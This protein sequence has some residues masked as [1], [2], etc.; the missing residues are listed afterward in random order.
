MSKKTISARF[1]E[2][3]AWELEFLKSSLGTK[4]TEVLIAAVH[5]LYEEQSQKNQKKTAFDFLKE[6]GFIGGT[7]G[8]ENDSVDYKNYIHERIKKKL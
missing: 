3:A 6:T 4:A 5:L 2:R 8:G 7:E 1:D